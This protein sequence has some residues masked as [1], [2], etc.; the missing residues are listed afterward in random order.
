MVY[1]GQEMVK[2]VIK[3]QIIKNLDFILRLMLFLVGVHV[4]VRA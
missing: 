4:H 2:E 1:V 3:V